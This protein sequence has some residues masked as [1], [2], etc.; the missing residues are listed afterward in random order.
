MFKITLSPQYSDHSLKLEKRGSILTIGDKPCDF[1][2]LADGS[3][4]PPEAIDNEYIVG[5]ITKGDGIV[6]ITV[7][8]PYS[9]AD[10]PNSVLFPKPIMM[11]ADGEIVFNEKVQA[12]D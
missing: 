6:N 11:I 12:D 4:V 7:L 5:G 8:M 3:D 2:Q 10:A 1:A 9:D